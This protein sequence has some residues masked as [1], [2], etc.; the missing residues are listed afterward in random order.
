MNPQPLHDY[1]IS[2]AFVNSRAAA[3][4]GVLAMLDLY[5]LRSSAWSV[6]RAFST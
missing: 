5:R 6:R 1:S 3:L 4:Y 2:L